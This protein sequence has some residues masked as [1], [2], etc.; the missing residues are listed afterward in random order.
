MISHTEAEVIFRFDDDDISLPWRI[1]WVLKHMDASGADYLMPG[2]FWATNDQN[3][4]DRK[5][6][7]EGGAYAQAAYK[8]LPF[9]ELGG[10]QLKSF[11]EDMSLEWTFRENGKRVV[12]VKAAQHEAS[13]L[14][15]WG[16]GSYHLSGYGKDGKG[17]DRIGATTVVP[18]EF[19]LCPHWVED[20]VQRVHNKSLQMN[21]PCDVC[22]NR[23]ITYEKGLF[24]DCKAEVTS[25]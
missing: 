11:G 16:T 4:N 20:Y 1:E 15:R 21:G 10:Y 23:Y 19:E 3:P 13:Y 2:Q 25:G 14:Y 22:G 7:Y 9:L 12:K 24:C 5:T 18:G 17:W 8:R 6:S